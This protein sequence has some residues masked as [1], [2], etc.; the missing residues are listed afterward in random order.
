MSNAAES[1]APNTFYKTVEVEITDEE[2]TVRMKDHLEI[3]FKI[4]AAKAERA[5]KMAEYGKDLKDLRQRRSEI[6]TTIRTK[7]EKREIACYQQEDFRTNRML[8]RRADTGEMIDER[9]LT[10]EER[11]ESLPGTKEPKAK[12]AAS[13]AANADTDEPPAADDEGSGGG[14]EPAPGSSKPAA[15]KVVRIRA[16]DAKKRSAG[17]KDPKDKGGK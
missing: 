13:E 9:P 7:K 17:R 11:Q 10:L 15:G 2:N 4:D 12:K 14:D 6:I 8:I 3:E 16:S 5:A 1:Q